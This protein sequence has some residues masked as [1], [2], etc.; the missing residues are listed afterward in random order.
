MHTASQAATQVYIKVQDHRSDPAGVNVELQ[1]VSTVYTF[2]GGSLE[3]PKWLLLVFYP[4]I[5]GSGG[6]LQMVLCH[7]MN[8]GCTWWGHS[9][10]L[11]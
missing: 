7:S 2:I 3:S 8:T 5:L 6:D 11:L 1:T 9:N 10:Y 4:K